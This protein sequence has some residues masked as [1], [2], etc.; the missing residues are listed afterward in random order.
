M[1]SEELT[2]PVY[3]DRRPLAE[4][5]LRGVVLFGY[6]APMQKSNQ[7]RSLG[8]VDEIRDRARDLVL[9]WLDE[10]YSLG[11]VAEVLDVSKSAVHRW[12]EGDR[13][14]RR[15]A[16]QVCGEAKTLAARLLHNSEA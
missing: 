9:G 6:D 7:N 8:A 1:R 14:V 10:G 2:R 5:V 11:A 12:K 15:T 4:A 3:T 16:A 13:P